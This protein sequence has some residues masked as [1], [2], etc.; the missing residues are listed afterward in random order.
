MLLCGLIVCRDLLLLLMLRAAARVC[1]LQQ[2]HLWCDTRAHGDLQAC[3]RCQGGQ[4]PRGWAASHR[5]AR[6]LLLL[7]CAGAL[8]GWQ[9]IRKVQWAQ[10]FAIGRL[11]Q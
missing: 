6:L 10:T 9:R 3:Q 11:L 4:Q 2:L 1:G 7:V 5:A 8:R